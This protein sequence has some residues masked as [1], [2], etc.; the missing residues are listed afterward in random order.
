MQIRPQLREIIFGTQTKAGRA[1]DIILLW[2]IILSVTVVCFDSIEEYHE[3][4]GK[5]LLQMEWFFTI[6]FTIEYGLRLYCSRQP[7]RYATS[8]FGV[9]DLISIIPTYLSLFILNTQF[10]II[11]RVLRLIRIFRVLQLVQFMGEANTLRQALY[12]SRHKIIV[13]LLGVLITT[14]VAGAIMYIVE[15][16]SSGFT[17]IPRGIYWAIVTIT[18]VGYGDISP[19]TPLGQ[20]ISSILMICGYGIL[21]VPTGIVSA[22][23]AQRRED[24][25]SRKHRENC[26][27]C[28]S[29]GHDEDARFCKLC[30]CSLQLH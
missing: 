9:V 26:T 20:F 30:G 16:P 4:H 10:L 11:I 22:Q 25:F 23:I 6:L 29:R 27:L 15:G 19:D 18:T 1:F 24:I 3:R 13:F 7:A 8:F 28:E 17:S 2:L 21:A 14:V 5:L 12:T